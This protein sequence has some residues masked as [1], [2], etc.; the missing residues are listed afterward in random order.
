M[1]LPPDLLEIL[2]C[3]NPRASWSITPSRAKSRVAASAVRSNRWRKVSQSCSAMRRNLSSL[4]A[5][6][7]ILTA[8]PVLAQE[9]NPEEAS[10][11]PFLLFP[12]GAKSTALGQAA[13]AD[14]GSTEAAFWNPA[15]LGYLAGNELAIHYASTFVSDNTAISAYFTFNRLG[16]IG[17]SAYL[18]DYGPQ[19][20]VGGSGVPVGRI[21]P[22][23]IELLA[24][25]ATSIARG[26][27]VGFN[28]KLIQLRQDCTGQCAS[29]QRESGTTPGVDLGVQYAVGEEQ[30]LRF[31]FAIRHLGFKLQLKNEE[32][33][34][35]LPTRVHIGAAYR[36]LLPKFRGSEQRFDVRILFD[37]D[38]QLGQYN[39]LE[40]RI[41][42]DMG[43]QET[44]R[45]RA[46]YAFL[47]S[48]SRGPSVGIGLRFGNLAVDVARIFFVSSSFDEPLH[49]NVSVNP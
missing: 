42:L 13:I 3:P 12:V 21:S 19:D 40:P 31:G 27:A 34:D 26:L 46:G 30:R 38:D 7:S 6:V 29:S 9:K 18:I 4:V 11:A 37:V 33:A 23:N 35:P 44:V 32:Q 49:I 48:Q 22:K 10:G 5:A 47:D 2:V 45:L 36:L 25:Y 17:V 41:G 28:Y 16:V 43:L 8:S 1:T 15:G 24:S 39:S 14:G 20:V